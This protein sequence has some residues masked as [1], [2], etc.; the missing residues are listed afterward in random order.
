MIESVLG[1]SVSANLSTGG[2]VAG[3]LTVTGDLGVGG[4]ASINLTS[5]VSN[6]T[7]IDATGTEALLVRANSD[8]GDVLI[9]N[10]S[11]AGV[12]AKGTLTVGTDGSGHDVTFYSG[13]AGDS[14]IW[15]SSEEKLTI[16]G[17]NGQVALAVADGNVTITD[18]LDVDG[19]TNLDVVDIDGAVDMASTVAIGDAVTISK[20]TDAEFVASIL[21]NQSD[22][23]DTTGIVSQRFDLEDTGGTAVD[24]GKILVGKEASFTATTSTQDSYMAF[25]TSLNGTLA[26]K[27]RIDSG[28]N[29]DVRNSVASAADA[30]A[31]LRLYSN[32]GAAMGSGHRLGVVEF[33]GAEDSSSNL[34][35]GARIEA[36]TDA[37]WSAS[38]NGADMVFY[39][40]DGNASETEA[41][42]MTAE[43]NV[44]LL[45]GRFQVKHAGTDTGLTGS[46]M[47]I[48]GGS[49]PVLL[50]YN[51]GGS[52]YLPMVFDAL[53]YSVKVSNTARMVIDS[54]SRI[55]L[56]NNDSGG[57]G[58]L[59]STSGNTTLG[60]LAG[61]A[62]ASGGHDNT[63]YGHGAGKLLT[64][65][66]DN[67]AFGAGALSGS[68]DGDGNTAIGFESL[69]TYEGSDTQGKNTAL[70]FKS[71][72]ALTTGQSNTSAGYNSAALMTTGDG[73]VAIGALTLGA[74]V[75]AE[76]FNVA[77]G[78]NSMGAA[79]EGSGNIDN[80]IA[81]GVNALNL[82]ADV[83]SNL[84]NNIAIGYYAL[85]DANYV[86]S[87]M[88]A[89]GKNS[90]KELED[91]DANTAVGK[92]TLKVL[93]SGDN[94]TA[95][96]TNA[97]D[98]ITTGSNNTCIGKG[99]DTSANNASN[100]TV[101]G[102]G[103]TGVAD[104]SV[105]L[106]DASVTAVYMASDSGAKVYA[107]GLGIGTT[108]VPHG[109]VGVGLVSVEGA[110]ADLATG[111]N[112]SFTT[113]SDDYP[114]MVL[115]NYQHDDVSIVFDAYHDGSAWK[116]SDASN[117]MIQKITN[118]FTFQYDSAV[119]AGSALTWNT[120]FSMNASGV[121]SGDFNDTSDVGLKENIKSIGDGLTI[122]NQ[123]NPVS[124]DWKQKSKGSNSGFIAQELEKILPNDVSGEDYIASDEEGK[125]GNIG[126][127]INVTGIVAHLVK[128]VQELS[129]KV[130]ALE[131]N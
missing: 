105:T 42:R 2:T 91:G 8:G 27:V 57:T 47:E 119:T 90:C 129:A 102:S 40:T 30:G 15:D 67:C 19:T 101:I 85:S 54:N 16:T 32:D 4:D 51:R 131:S 88:I 96:G 87:G 46:G 126:K 17:T 26:E 116:S 1:K 38:E 80:N 127:S 31:K 20:D 103:V 123:M 61:N 39:T 53:N 22:A 24:S 45:S 94:N 9:V 100:Q 84:Y 13:T 49:N 125:A 50:S 72:R 75:S 113:A 60:Y 12:T 23:A 121:M 83:N 11:T 120:G 3:D 112:I 111:P 104:N 37:A 59:D 118:T 52:A 95:F 68:L 114:L 56:S 55:S 73:N 79:D 124:F 41:M 115:Q 58:G 62:I 48:H 18:D 64:T 7:I 78:Y 107:G 128:A 5:V 43:S 35:N 122:V 36:V 86:G 69:A 76:S 70:G 10:T 74:A 34:I 89:I 130:E 82:K 65:G 93:T 108:T 98:V 44:E 92:E 110:N 71:S 77:L 66:E 33:A 21:V 29:V 63:F 97:G 106:G 28:G 81:I 109:G 6:S 117:F 25:H 99:A 14:F